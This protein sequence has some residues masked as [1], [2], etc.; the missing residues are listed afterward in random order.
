M[1]LLEFNLLE[2]GCVMGY[3]PVQLQKIKD[4]LTFGKNSPRNDPFFYASYT[5]K[6]EKYSDF[7][8]FQ[9]KLIIVSN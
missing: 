1:R 6:F 5:A 2:I 4:L 3:F 7:S 8:F 9:E